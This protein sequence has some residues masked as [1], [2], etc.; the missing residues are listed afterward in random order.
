VVI[1]IDGENL[2]NSLRDLGGLQITDF[3]KFKKCLAGGKEIIRIV[4]YQSLTEENR[5]RTLGFFGHLEK[6]GYEIQSKPILKGKEPKSE[7]D[8]LI[9]DGI[10]RCA[11]DSN[12]DTIILVSGDHHFIEAVVFAK[13]MG[14]KVIVVSTPLFLSEELKR[15]SDEWIDLKEI[16]IGITE[17]SEIEEKREEA[18]KKLWEGKKITMPT[19]EENP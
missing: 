6:Q 18:L 13:E 12:V 14:K 1:L 17:K 19:L 3:S 5:G 16:I 8:S 2:W 15:V 4:Y 9:S 7:I 11:I 10:Y